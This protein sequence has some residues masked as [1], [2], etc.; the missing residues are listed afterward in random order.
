VKVSVVLPTYNERE[1]IIPLIH[2][3]SAILADTGVDYQIVVVDDESPDDTAGMIAQY[4]FSAEQVLL[5]R[6]N[7]QRGLATAVKAGIQA[8]SGDV[9]IL[10]DADFSHN[11]EDLPK[12]LSGL[13]RHD[14]INGSRYLHSGG[15]RGNLRAKLFSKAINRFLG[16]I[17][18]L[19]TTDNTNGFLAMRRSVMN[20]WDLNRI[21]F[22]YGDFHFR[23]MYKAVRSSVAVREVPVVYH[24]RCR[25][26]AKTRFLRDGW[27]YI[28]SALKIRL[29]HERL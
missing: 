29:G 2:A 22:G 13:E 12:M 10:M 25:G 6:R 20:G 28:T 7:G 17:L 21:F 23:L 19:E 3:I 9:I 15:F 26:K 4:S 14:L 24:P 11:P 27:G 16:R 18:N 1:N 5:I 8:S